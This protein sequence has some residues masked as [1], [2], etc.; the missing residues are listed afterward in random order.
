MKQYV[1][2]TIQLEE[3]LIQTLDQLGAEGFELVSM[4]DFTAIFRRETI[5]ASKYIYKVIE[6]EDAINFSS[7]DYSD[8]FHKE[9]LE[10]FVLC[11]VNRT[12]AIFRKKTSLGFGKFNVE[13]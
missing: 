2:K 5:S 13:R 11:T 6:L 8:M 3:G 10:G 1:Y 4:E 12:L 7:I 9:N